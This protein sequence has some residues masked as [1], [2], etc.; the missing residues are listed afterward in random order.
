VWLMRFIYQLYLGWILIDRCGKH[1]GT[2]L[3]YLRDGNVPLPANTTDIEEIM[4]EAKFY[5]IGGLVNLSEKALESR[6]AVM[7]PICQVPFITSEEE[8]KQF[9]ANATKPVVE[10]LINRHNNKYSYTR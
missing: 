2:I 9:I 5:C 8:R 7:N 4:A 10:L 3:N 6:N 1:F